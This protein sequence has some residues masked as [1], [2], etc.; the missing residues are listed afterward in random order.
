[1]NKDFPK[2]KL[3]AMSDEKIMR[4]LFDLAQFIEAAQHSFSSSHFKKL[5]RYHSFLA[6]SKNDSIQMPV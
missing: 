6:A 2:D 1:M 5:K 4:V 3:L